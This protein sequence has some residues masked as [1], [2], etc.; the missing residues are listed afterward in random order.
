MLLTL[1]NKLQLNGKYIQTYISNKMG[2]GITNLHNYYNKTFKVNYLQIDK[3]SDKI[4][5]YESLKNKFSPFPTSWEL[6]WLV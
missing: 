4:T 1:G 2:K 6:G 3:N 5:I